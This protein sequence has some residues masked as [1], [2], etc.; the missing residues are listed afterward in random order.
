[1]YDYIQKMISNIPTNVKGKQATSAPGYLFKINKDGTKL[2]KSTTDTF[3]H[4]MVQMLYPRKQ[5]RPDIQLGTAFLSTPVQSPGE[6][7]YKKLTHQMCFLQATEYLPLT[8]Q[9]NGEGTLIYIDGAHAVHG[10][11]KGH[12]GVQV[13]EGTGT[14][15]ASLTKNR[16]N[17]VSST[18]VE[19][20]SV[21]ENLPKNIWYRK[22]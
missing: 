21:G 7:D 22:F 1:M 15:Y 8:I 9:N 20:V 11:M 6:D 19:I 14:I 16:L 3:H 10:N 17:V 2:D 18:E 12:A 4:I 5:A 13:T